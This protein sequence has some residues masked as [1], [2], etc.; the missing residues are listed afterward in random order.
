M[1]RLFVERSRQ[2]ELPGIHGSSRMQ[3]HGLE[4]FKMTS[5]MMVRTA[6][7]A[8]VAGGLA[9][10][11]DA[12]VVGLTGYLNSSAVYQ[13]HAQGVGGEGDITT[14]GTPIN[15]PVSLSTP[16]HGSVMSTQFTSSG[17]SLMLN[18]T[19]VANNQ[20]FWI[21]QVFQ[22]TEAVNYSMVGM[23]PNSGRVY[24][25]YEQ[26]STFL[27]DVNQQTGPTFDLSGT[28]DVGLYRFQYMSSAYGATSATLFNLAFTP[29][30]APGA[31]ALIGAAGL[32]G[33][34]RRR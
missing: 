22:V 17:F 1:D 14:S 7:V 32:V 28:L 31:V 34:R 29:V 16:V 4:E 26:N 27:V 2:R 18:S 10:A 15:G 20:S 33:R 24:L 12:G 9:G 21:T 6:A 23:F 5:S 3:R 25:K 30:P 11:A 19:S 8:A 13:L